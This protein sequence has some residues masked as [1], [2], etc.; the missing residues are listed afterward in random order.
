MCDAERFV[1][2]ETR[3]GWKSSRKFLVPVEYEKRN[4]KGRAIQEYDNTITEEDVLKFDRQLRDLA[5]KGIMVGQADEDTSK[6]AKKY[7]IEIR[8]HE[9]L[10]I[11]ELAHLRN[12][13]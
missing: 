3:Y 11:K 1:E 2:F 10:R 9:K 4:E 12:D 8:K 13:A 7:G 5:L 6:K